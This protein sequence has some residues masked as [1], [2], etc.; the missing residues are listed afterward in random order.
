MSN[1]QHR[2][3]GS[4]VRPNL[5]SLSNWVIPP[6]VR[7]W[8]YLFFE[9]ISILCTLLVLYTILSDRALRRAL[10]NH[11]II[12]LLF[13]GLIYEI[14]N[15][16]WILHYNRTGIPMFSTTTFYLIWVFLDYTFY[17]VQIALFA[18]AT[19]ERHILIFHDKWVG[20]REKRLVVH[21]GPMISIILYYLIY[22]SIIHFAPFCENSFDVF[23]AGGIFVPCIFSRTFLGSWDLIIHQF[24]PTL[25]IVFFSIFLVV[26]VVKQRRRFNQAITWRRHRKLTVQ[27]LS[28]SSLYLLFNFPWTILIFAYQYGLSE[29]IFSIPLVYTAYLYYYV[30][31]LFPFACCG[32]FRDL[33]KKIKRRMLTRVNKKRPKNASQLFITRTNND[34]TVKRSGTNP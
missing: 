33:R 10:H 23:L 22:Y 13:I 28:I 29:D 17:S 15:I 9:I 19:I 14:T 34:A 24:I 3:T 30:I 32:S 6:I 4:G 12:V 1:D 16:P 20:T 5:T 11:I 8:S 27:L 31:F 2:S 21:Y 18:W 25:I 26:R 7:F